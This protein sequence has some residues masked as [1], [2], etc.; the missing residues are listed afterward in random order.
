[1]ASNSSTAAT[2]TSSQ[3]ES[4][5]FRVAGISLALASAAFIGASYIIK[6][7]GLLD[8]NALDGRRP[9]TSHGYL[10]SAMWWTGM[11]MMLVGE[12]CN[13]AAYAFQPAIIVTPLGAI[14][15]VISA[16]LSDI[17]LKEK[18]NLSGKIG[19]AQC[20]LGA[21]LLVVN[22]P[23]GSATDSLTSFWV[24]V[25]D[26]GFMSYLVANILLLAYLILY[27]AKKWGEKTPMVY[28]GICSIV[29]SYVVVVLQ[30]VGSAIVY[31]VQN[32]EDSQ[33]KDWT[34]YL[35]IAFVVC[36]GV[37][38]INFLNKALNIF[39]TAIVTPIYF[40]CFT[41]AT[42][43]CSAVLFRD[44]AFTSYVQLVSALVGFLVI[45]GGVA[46][47]FAYN[48]KL[49]SRANSV[50]NGNGSCPGQQQA[51][52]N[53]LK[54]H[55]SSSVISDFD[56]GAHTDSA[57]SSPSIPPASL[58]TL[59]QYQQQQAQLHAQ[60]QYG[61]TMT[62]GDMH[63][64][65]A[66]APPQRAY[67]SA[68]TATAAAGGAG[69]TGEDTIVG[70]GVTSRHVHLPAGQV[71]GAMYQQSY[72]GMVGAGEDRDSRLIENAGPAGGNGGWV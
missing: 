50:E 9:G 1:M 60:Q 49:S 21:T 14:S 38:Q 35:L 31:S 32:P 34:L 66:P 44:F 5:T 57:A 63:R 26:W 20:V 64:A 33:G 3:T 59:S 61:Q 58:M 17:F 62:Q 51:G 7:K 48:A 11:T 4:A 42:L 10:K 47:L 72:K 25:W 40:V 39:S 70:G 28:I 54:S 15:V 30:V 36:C 67:W 2:S 46:L 53:R 45:V 65:R 69:A 43:V 8:A 29:G 41:T 6:K 27:A 56:S 68:T 23:P 22:S 16:I 13:V 55:D 52:K 18:L 12:L 37:T 71:I 19:C 24:K